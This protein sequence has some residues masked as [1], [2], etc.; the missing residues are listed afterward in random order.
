MSVDINLRSSTCSDVKAL[1][2]PVSRLESIL[3]KLIEL[4]PRQKKQITL[5]PLKDIDSLS[6]MRGE[7]RSVGN[8]PTFKVSLV[9]GIKAGWY[10]LEAALV[11]NN[12]SRVATIV[13][14][15]GSYKRELLIP[16]VLRGSIRE[17]IYIPDGVKEMMWVPTAARGFFTQSPLQLHKI[18]R[19]E[20]ILRRAYR[21]IYDLWRFRHIPTEGRGE[22]NWT[23]L[24]VNLQDSYQKSAKLR[25]QRVSGNDYSAFIAQYD[26]LTSSR[27]RKIRSQIRGLS[28]YPMFSIVIDLREAVFEK[29]NTCLDSIVSQ[30][31]G[32]WELILVC[33]YNLDNSILA[34]VRTMADSDHRI[35]VVYF[36][37][38]V[39][40]IVESAQLL[41]YAI[42]DA[43]GEWVIRV[44]HD[45]RLPLHSLFQFASEAI[46]FP[47]AL[48][49]YGDDDDINL[50]GQR[51]NPRFKPDWNPDLLTAVDYIGSPVAFLRTRLIKLGG[52]AVGF[53]GAEGYELSLRYMKN[54]PNCNVRHIPK[55]LYHRCS[56]PTDANNIQRAHD[57]GLLALKHYFQGEAVGV[58]AGI[59]QTLYRVKYP[60]PS[61]Q[62]L[63]SIIVPTR[64]KVSLL[65]ACV[66][67]VEER[68]SYPNWELVIVDN[69]SVEH[70][71][72]VYLDS[73]KSNR[74]I[75]V[76][77]YDAPFNYS[78]INN[79]AV[80]HANGNVIALLNNDIEILTDDWLSEMVSHALRP[81]IGAVGAKL[82]YPDGVVQHAGVV[83]GIGGIAGH[84]FR[85]LPDA[86]VGYC[87]RAITTQNFLAVTGAC[88][89]VDRRK[90]IEVAGLNEDLAVAFNDVDFC[91]KLISAGYRNI[92]T[93]FAR[94][95]HHE[96][97]TRGCDDT[98]EK[99]SIFENE[100]SII[101]RNWPDFV[102]RD[103]YYNVNLSLS[104][105]NIQFKF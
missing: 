1:L 72:H 85:F 18:S 98:P 12:G 78:A 31:Y 46:I 56:K 17:V 34:L 92:Y 101:K 30:L 49:I 61:M 9:G 25:I 42:S 94:M 29:L 73:L 55:V 76:L 77:R 95:I 100:S 26:V 93:P 57:A 51:A 102:G 54:L 81:E 8:A 70:E 86:E 39:G 38:E 103:P 104:S 15:F 59:T 24:L 62:P 44:N 23:G 63:V 14:D 65:R 87:N 79:Y 48:V 45:D 47:H 53:D 32:Y 35:R 37:K 3:E 75:R 6:Q 52:Y 4:L 19:A 36:E 2:L 60:L 88:L 22:F 33:T 20:S 67:S 11:R 40:Q 41:N 16:S 7:F 97:L 105:E 68:T 83:L 21:V 28:R 84:I 99:K 64:D 74:R 82:L 89:V 96:S 58:E 71:T 13:L 90:F 50:D 43:V 5:T 69:G 27:V 91:L 10:Y 66:Q 80:E